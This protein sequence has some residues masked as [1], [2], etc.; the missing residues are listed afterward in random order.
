MDAVALATRL[1]RG[2]DS[3]LEHTSAVAAQTR[4]VAH[5]VEPGWRSP[6][7][8]AAWLHDTGYSPEVVVTSFHPLDGARWLRDHHWPTETCRLVAWHTGAF[9]EAV[10]YGLGEELAAE[11][12][13]PPS[14]ASAALAWAD[15]TSSPSGELWDPEQRLTDILNRYLPGSRVH[16]ATLR[17]SPS[18][19][20]AVKEIDG[21]L[22]D[23]R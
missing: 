9:E 10:L 3:R 7:N 12:R 1:L 22:S 18:L 11:F 19:L 13:P 14:L 4:R 2:L 15:L 16:E 8:D 17:S 21:L 20:A 5:L 6:L 23:Q